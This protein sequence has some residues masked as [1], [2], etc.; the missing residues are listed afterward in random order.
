MFRINADGHIDPGCWLWNEASEFEQ[1]SL[2]P[3]HPS[4]HSQQQKHTE[5]KEKKRHNNKNT[6]LR[7]RTH[8]SQSYGNAHEKQEQAE[9]IA[10]P[11][12]SLWRE[13]IPHHSTGNCREQYENEGVVYTGAG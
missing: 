1:S 7:S 10:A 13:E 11:K 4:G 12:P 9:Y 2:G 3:V 8:L 6:K 5:I